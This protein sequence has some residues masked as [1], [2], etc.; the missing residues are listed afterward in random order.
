MTSL[1]YEIKQSRSL[2]GY[3]F[4][5]LK[6]QWTVY[7]QFWPFSFDKFRDTA[8]SK[9][10]KIRTGLSNQILLYSI[11]EIWGKLFFPFL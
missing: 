7:M 8:P 2:T 11:S 1:S 5:Y 9:P 6:L 3:T 4:I 10:E